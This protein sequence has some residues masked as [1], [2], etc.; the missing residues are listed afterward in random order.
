MI[1]NTRVG[2]VGAARRLL[3][4]M[5][6]AQLRHDEAY[7]REILALSVADRLKH[8]ALHFAKYTGHFAAGPVTE[9][10]VGVNAILVDS[11]II[12]LASA[13]SLNLDLGA[14]L[15]TSGNDDVVDL[16]SLGRRLAVSLERPTCSDE[17]WLLRSFAQH[18]GRLAKAC[19]SVDH[20]EAFP[21][22]E[23]MQEEILALCR[24]VLAEASGQNLDLCVQV[25]ER[26][27]RVESR[28]MFHEFIKSD[29]VST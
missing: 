22:R 6:W 10:K 7:H 27:T 26:L 15:V 5:Q 14:R 28:S 24:V 20:L 1:F 18:T 25:R 2:E 29:G 19:E 23:A 3:L 21:F 16:S 17:L 13:N 12:V 9:R 4:E 11:F 8:M